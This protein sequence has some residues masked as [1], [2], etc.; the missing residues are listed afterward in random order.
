MIEAPLQETLQVREGETISFLCSVWG[1]PEPIV[2]WY[3]NELT[4]QFPHS[5]DDQVVVE[6]V[7][8]SNR[9]YHLMHIRHTIL[10]DEATYWCKATTGFLASIKRFD[11]RIN[12]IGRLN[13]NRGGT[14]NVSDIFATFWGGT[15]G[16]REVVLQ[17]QLMFIVVLSVII[18]FVIACILVLIR[19]FRIRSH[20][21]ASLRSKKVEILRITKTTMQFNELLQVQKS[22]SKLLQNDE[23][24]L[25]SD[26][27][28]NANELIGKAP[29]A[30]LDRDTSMLPLVQTSL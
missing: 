8:S 20:S 12:L 13:T 18:I 5:N 1:D 23:V 6:A 30:Q 21:D 14:S 11:L 27:S 19:R 16:W 22:K 7:T 9:T 10:K 15:E 3:K 24:S 29:L 2:Q 25:R 4:H 28:R 26:F 17:W